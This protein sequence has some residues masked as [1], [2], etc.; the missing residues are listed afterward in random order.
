MNENARKIT[1]LFLELC[2][3]FPWKGQRHVMKCTWIIGRITRLVPIYFWDESLLF[4]QWIRNRAKKATI[5]LRR[6]R[7]SIVDLANIICW[8]NKRYLSLPICSVSKTK[9]ARAWPSSSRRKNGNQSVTRKKKWQQ[10]LHFKAQCPLFHAPPP[11]H[12]LPTPITSFSL[13]SK[14]RLQ[15]SLISFHWFFFHIYF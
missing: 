15:S 9:K 10:W 7:N 4:K 14:S 2:S 1:R 5:S 13:P 6:T 3:H 11:T 12:S 8:Q